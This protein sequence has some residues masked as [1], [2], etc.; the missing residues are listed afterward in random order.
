MNEDK[1][2]HS[3]KEAT[4]QATFELARVRELAAAHN[5][6]AEDFYKRHLRRADIFRHTVAACLFVTVAFCGEHVYAGQPPCTSATLARGVS[7]NDI[8]CAV[9]TMLTKL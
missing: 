4:I 3:E 9:D 2:I 7:A 5:I 6:E 8:C 1:A